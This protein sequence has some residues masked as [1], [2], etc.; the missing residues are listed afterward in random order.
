MWA[1]HKFISPGAAGINCFPITSVKNIVAVPADKNIFAFVAIYFI[2]AISAYD[3]I[4]LRASGYGVVASSA[5]K[6]EFF[7]TIGLVQF[8][9]YRL[10]I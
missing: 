5:N 9:I 10:S 2:I 8:H 7:G 6:K 3:D 1:E 4:F